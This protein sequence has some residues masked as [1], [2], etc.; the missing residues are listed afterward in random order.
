MTRKTRRQRL[1]E[2]RIRQAKLRKEA[3]EKRKPGRDDMARLLL[4]LMLREAH[5]TARRQ[6][7]TEPLD[8]LCAL[9]VDGLEQQGFDAHEAEA[10]FAMLERKYR[11]QEFPG[12]IKRHFD[13]SIDTL[14]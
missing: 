8:K 11:I 4:W 6:R 5:E 14:I 12:R 7:S 9:L 3:R 13:Q 2:Q 1:E 10:L